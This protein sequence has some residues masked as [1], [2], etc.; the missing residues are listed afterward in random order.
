[1][2]GS[3]REVVGDAAIRRGLGAARCEEDAQGNE[4]QDIAEDVA[5]AAARDVTSVSRIDAG[6]HPRQRHDVHPRQ[7]VGGDAHRHKS[8]HDDHHCVEHSNSEE[9]GPSKSQSSA[10]LRTAI[11]T[12]QSE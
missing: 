2:A 9:R 5:D 4:E 11:L 12:S 6:G 1:M 8:D 10:F 7:F 3:A